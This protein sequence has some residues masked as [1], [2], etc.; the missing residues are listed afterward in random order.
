LET[1]QKLAQDDDILMYADFLD[2]FVC[3]ESHFKS[4]LQGPDLQVEVVRILQSVA[5]C[6]ELKMDMEESTNEPQNYKYL[7][8]NDARE[9][10]LIW[11][12]IVSFCSTHKSDYKT[13]FCGTPTH[14]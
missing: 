9:T 1:G 8:S 7:I 2:L 4:G 13:M 11:K 3:S 10:E 6:Q 14:H 12:V 5:T